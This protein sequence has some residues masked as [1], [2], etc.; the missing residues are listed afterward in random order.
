MGETDIENALL[1]ISEEDWYQACFE[2][3]QGKS[4]IL[5]EDNSYKRKGKLFRFAAGRG[6]EPDLI[7]R[8]LDQLEK[9]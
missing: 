2:L 3:L 6:F 8:A 4:A 9:E 7:Y 5:K 1:Q